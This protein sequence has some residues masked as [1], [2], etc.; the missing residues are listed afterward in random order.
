MTMLV[1]FALV[2]L[3]LGGVIGEVGGA[4]GG[5]ALG[6]AIGLHVSYRRRLSAL[7]DD[8]GRLSA[9]ITL[10]ERPAREESTT[11]PVAPAAPRDYFESLTPAATTE[12]LPLPLPLPPAAAGPAPPPAPV[13]APAAAPRPLFTQ[14][15]TAGAPL[16]DFRRPVREPTEPD[17]FE[18]VREYFTGGNL[19]VRAGII[20]LFFGVAFLLKF[21]ADRHM[22]PIE[23]RLAG[24]AL[25]GVALLVI[26][27]RLRDRQRA[28][29]LAL[30]GGGVGLLYL[31]VFAALRLYDLLPPT[32]AFALLV[33]IAASSAF[34]AIGQNSL[35]LA[36]LGATGGF[37]APVLASTG[38]GSHVVLFSF[39]AL[40]DAG[41][42]AIAWFKAWRPLNLLA[43]V[44]TYA[45]GT[46][47][48]VLR[49]SPEHFA[50]TEPFVIL[51][52]AMFVAVAV[53]FALRRA[54]DLK[55]YVDG[56]IVFGTPVMTMFL[57]SALV[58]HRPYAMAFSALALSAVYVALAAGAWRA[59]R[60]QLR[61]IAAAFL[62]LGVA[63][64]TLA[65]PLALDGHWTAATWALE[66]AAILWVGLRQRRALPIASGVLLQVAA[67]LSYVVHYDVTPGGAP[68]VN[69][70]FVGA[71][72]I[73]LAGLASARVLRGPVDEEW[74][75]ARAPPI[76][77]ALF[78]W[79]V[80]GIG[81]LDRTVSAD[82]FIPAALAFSAVTALGCAALTRW[83][84]WIEFR[85]PT[86]LLLPAMVVCAFGSIDRGHFLWGGGLLAWPFA[87]VAWAWL[88]RRRDR[89]GAGAADAAIHVA[90]LW[91]VVVLATIEAY[92]QV[93]HLRIG[94]PAWRF[95]VVA[96]PALLALQ[97]IRARRASWP[98]SA[99]P[100]AWLGVGAAGL[101]VALWLWSLVANTSDAAAWPLP[102]LPLVNPVELA[103]ALSLATV[104]GWL[105]YV[106]REAP[107]AWRPPDVMPI[108][109]PA[110]AF[111]VFALLTTMLLRSIHHYVGVDYSPAALARSTIVQAAL[112]IFWGTIA[113]G[114]MVAGTR[115]G[116]RVV[117][118]CGAVLLG[119]V[120]AKLFLVDLSRSATVARIV[121]F[122]G[123]G[124]L[125]LVIGRFSPVPPARRVAEVPT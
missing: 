72:F 120:L 100:A 97:W 66:G 14:T 96:L 22:L 11:R 37:L 44:F 55:D 48:G 104:A 95:A 67:A 16:E 24:V 107:A 10:A 19:V 26:G 9:R 69:S 92:W 25:G 121:S 51:F 79:F 36:A 86:L 75:I 119:V 42:V 2:G 70:A 35:A 112:S 89:W 23:L 6:Y 64:L 77:W 68:L 13:T 113:L 125:M 90:T 109:V 52:F 123:V 102:Y 93:K 99:Q 124:V 34:L 61:L 108:I 3:I 12:P 94:A 17:L 27:W 122:I 118:F 28:Y 117:W 76:Y 84:D 1:V 57:Q 39:Y 40:L 85:T 111:A 41:I 20:V 81:E 15:T 54:T 88:L 83:G 106:Q 87:L 32:L 56:T 101:A 73:A 29:G 74:R 5:A 30:E 7:E 33:A 115:R 80:A 62:A 53:L 4:L 50:T 18:W 63:F 91:F 46:A 103:Q 110:L 116:A 65:I 114:A 71:S 47:W 8:L 82:A 60:E 105:L 21:A 43:F 45:I 98:M 49:Y 31:T 59:K 78:W 58:H 38:Q